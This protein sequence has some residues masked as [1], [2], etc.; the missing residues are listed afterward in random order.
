MSQPLQMDPVTAAILG[1]LF[2]VLS[3]LLATGYK[4]ISDERKRKQQI[5]DDD[6]KRKWQIEDDDKR[7]KWQLEDVHL[8]RRLETL[9]AKL[10]ECR[11][12]VNHEYDISAKLFNYQSKY[13]FDL[14]EPDG[15]A[16]D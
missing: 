9:N 14:G 12:Y 3:F 7:R 8:Q 4:V 13:I 16:L 11:A 15:V 1:F 2:S 5:E 10:I 6:K